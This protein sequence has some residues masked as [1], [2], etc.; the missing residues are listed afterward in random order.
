MENLSILDVHLH[1]NNVLG[2]WKCK[3]LKTGTVILFFLN[4]K[5]V[6]S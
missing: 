6:N 2:A 5:N 1:D 3:L 4:Y